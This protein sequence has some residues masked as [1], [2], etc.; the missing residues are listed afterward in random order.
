[1][2]GVFHWKVVELSEIYKMQVSNPCGN[3]NLSRYGS[4]NVKFRGVRGER[5]EVGRFEVDF[6]LSEK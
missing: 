6:S 5:F 4:R 1:M 3:A 2:G